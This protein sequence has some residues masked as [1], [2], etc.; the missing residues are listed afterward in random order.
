MILMFNMD[1]YKICEYIYSV[2]HLITDL[3]IKL[4]ILV[5]GS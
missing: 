4:Q 5:A 1:I 2:E 3:E